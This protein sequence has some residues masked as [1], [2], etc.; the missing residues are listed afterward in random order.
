[1]KAIQFLGPKS[2]PQI[3]LNPS[4][5]DLPPPTGSQILIKVYS[6]GITHDEINWPEVYKTTSHIPGHDVS[7]VITALGPSYTGPLKVGDAVYAMLH[8]D[9]GQGQAEYVLVDGEEEEVVRKPGSL[10]HAQ[11]AALPIPVL[12]AWEALFVHAGEESLGKK[13]GTRVLVT[14]AS[15]A[16]G[17][18]LVQLARLKFGGGLDIVALASEGNFERLRELGASECVDYKVPDWEE[19]VGKV[20]VVID[21]AGGEVLAKAWE[22]VKSPGGVIVTVADP[23]PAWAFGK[24]VPEELEMHPGVRA[25]YFVIG[26]N[27][28]A[29]KEVGELID[30]GKIK[31]LPVV[32]FPVEKALDAWEFAGQRSRNG[33]VV[34]NF[35]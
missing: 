27:A 34:I 4:Y 23:A 21:M 24:A 10:S 35:V 15:G 32:E 26:L 33:K 25:V 19:K 31:A 17:L 13:K 12:T 7:G 9:R 8:V 3:T 30:L 29:L 14:G 22:V 2:N 1:M 18:I 5:P 20:D 28:E 16:V 11:A 6:A